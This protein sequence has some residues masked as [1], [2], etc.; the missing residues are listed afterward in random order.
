VNP[1][2]DKLEEL[3][4]SGSMMTDMMYPPVSK[5]LAEARKRAS[6]EAHD[7]FQ[8][9]GKKVFVDGAL[10]SKTKQI[11]AVAAAHVTQ[12]PFC[13]RGHTKAALRSGASPEEI[14]E[15]IWIAAEMR[16]GAA[17]AH[18]LI[19][20]AAIEDEQSGHEP[21]E[22]GGRCEQL[23]DPGTGQRRAR[24]SNRSPKIQRFGR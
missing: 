21:Q 23:D 20:L 22:P 14:M 16:A 13:I 9:F 18:S 15:A 5:S 3:V 2:I 19:A 11:I 10:S 12:C 1:D 24:G 7:A 4:G 8:T 6:P 17:Y